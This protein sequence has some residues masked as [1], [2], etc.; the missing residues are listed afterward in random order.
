MAITQFPKHSLSKFVLQD[1]LIIVHSDVCGRMQNEL[2]G[3]S[4]YFVTLFDKTSHWTVMYHIKRK[5]DAFHAFLDY[6]FFVERETGKR[7]KP[8]FSDGGKEHMSN[9]LQNNLNA[10]GIRHLRTC[11][12]TPQQNRI[13]KE[14]NRTLLDIVRCM[15]RETSVYPMFCAESLVTPSYILNRFPSQAISFQKTLY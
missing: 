6:M 12:N 10:R 15:L 2:T 4:R 5:S 14:L 13:A 7:I 3:V 8:L 9:D 11:A 1:V